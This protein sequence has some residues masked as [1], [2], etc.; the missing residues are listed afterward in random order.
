V[1]FHSYV[2]L[3]EV[4]HNLSPILWDIRREKY[5][6]WV[7]LAPQALG[8]TPAPLAEESGEISSTYFL[9]V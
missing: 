6:A 8:L 4:I 9:G 2:S 3:P 5:P 1:I 7:L